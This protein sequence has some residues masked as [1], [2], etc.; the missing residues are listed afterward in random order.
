MLARERGIFG[1]GLLVLVSACTSFPALSGGTCGNGVVDPATEDC[2]T[3]PTAGSPYCR[4]PGTVGECRYDCS[5]SSHTCPPGFG[6]GLDGICRS[7][8]GTFKF[9]TSFPGPS[10]QSVSLADFNGDGR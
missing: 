1:A 6:C 9:E 2:D 8:S 4:R 5:G 3:Y 10:V 7:G